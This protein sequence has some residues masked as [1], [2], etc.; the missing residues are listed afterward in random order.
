MTK[1]NLEGLPPPTGYYEI[2]NKL[3]TKEIHF[4][5]FNLLHIA[6]SSPHPFTPLKALH[7][8]STKTMIH[9]THKEYPLSDQDC[10]PSL[11]PTHQC[12]STITY[13]TTNLAKNRK[14]RY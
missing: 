4:L 10:A 8:S 1:K 13:K 7:Q 5:H 14:I 9:T 12:H 3:H 2:P 11:K 6:F